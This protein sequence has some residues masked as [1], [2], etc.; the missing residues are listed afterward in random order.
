[1]SVLDDSALFTDVQMHACFVSLLCEL[2]LLCWCMTA[3]VWQ[4]PRCYPCCPS[5]SS[6]CATFRV[7]RVSS[8]CLLCTHTLLAVYI[9]RRVK[10]F[11][12]ICMFPYLGMYRGLHVCTFHD[13]IV[14]YECAPDPLRREQPVSAGWV[15]SFPLFPARCFNI[16]LQ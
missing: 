9:T 7:G 16:F 2:G 15:A 1:M 10:P 5:S 8:S 4:L 14:E 3:G 13:N 11:C 6:T 12:L